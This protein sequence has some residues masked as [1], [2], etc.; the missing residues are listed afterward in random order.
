VTLTQ[1]PGQMMLSGS[2]QRLQVV[3]STGY[4]NTAI[5]EEDNGGDLVLF[6]TRQGQETELLVFNVKLKENVMPGEKRIVVKVLVKDI[7][8]EYFQQ[9]V[10]RL[11]S[12]LLVQLLPALEKEQDATLKLR[13][14]EV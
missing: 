8:I 7:N 14:P 2:L 12:Y 1:S 5:S 6:D 10:L 11:I 4:P 9:P 3:D 13:K